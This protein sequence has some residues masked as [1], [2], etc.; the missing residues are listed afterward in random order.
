MKDSHDV[1]DFYEI[2]LFEWC[3]ELWQQKWLILGVTLF[4]I[5]ASGSYAF[6][7]NPVYEIKVN[8][9]PPSNSDI[10]DFNYGRAG[11]SGLSP[12]SIKDIYSIFAEKLQSDALRRQ[13]FNDVYL[14]SLSES[15]KSAGQDKLYADFT[16]DLVI[17]VA[18][19]DASDRYYTVVVRSQDPTKTVEWASSYA[20]SAGELA[21][22]A[23]IANATKE[24]GV[25]AL[26][27]DQQIATLREVGLQVRKDKIEHLEEALVVAKSVGLEQPP[28]ITAGSSSE[29]MGR[30]DGELAYMRGSKALEAEL[31]NFKSRQSDDAYISGLRDLQIKRDFYKGIELKKIDGVVYHLDGK[32]ELPGSPIAPRKILILLLGL[33][34]GVVVGASVALFRGALKKNQRRVR[35]GTEA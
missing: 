23:V 25:L 22:Q 17:N 12:F 28:L 6:M 1:N 27:Y 24:A 4:S 21:R 29:L 18:G 3:R 19:R 9:F 31:K 34:C 35:G 13:F 15:R 11:S 32:A 20:E 7:E 30:V 26:N 5:L 33:L 16:K 14:P 2:D 8:L 10:A